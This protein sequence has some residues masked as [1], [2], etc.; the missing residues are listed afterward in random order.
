MPDGL[1]GIV[2]Q[3][4]MTDQAD[5]FVWSEG[6]VR[7][8]TVFIIIFN[9]MY[10]LYPEAVAGSD[11]STGIVR[12]ENIFKCNTDIPGSVKD[13]LLKFIPFIIW[14]KYFF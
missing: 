14:N 9:E 8:N 3:W 11:D 2:L 10:I 6:N 1:R 7:V 4:I 12:L 5:P 13:E